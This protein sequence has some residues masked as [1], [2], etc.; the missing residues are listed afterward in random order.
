MEEIVNRVQNSGLVAVDLADYLPEQSD[1]SEFDFAPRLWNGLILKEKDFRD[2]LAAH[3]WSSY[4]NKHV[5]L[6]C[7]VDA[8]LPSWAFMIVS[9]KLIGIAKTITIGSLQD[10]KQTAMTYS[11]QSL[12]TEEFKDGKLIIKGCSDIP[13]PEAVMSLF[14]QRV[15]PVCSSVMYGEPCST[16]PIFKRPKSKTVY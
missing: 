7:S 14:L 3:D 1:L 11:I 2:F 4:T 8:I 10:A 16:V 12:N 13:N 6:H 9:S 15:Q 5:Y